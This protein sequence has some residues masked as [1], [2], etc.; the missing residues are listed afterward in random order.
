MAHEESRACEQGSWFVVLWSLATVARLLVV[1]P[2]RRP[3]LPAGL[4][5]E[6][7]SLPSCG[8]APATQRHACWSEVAACRPHLLHH[9]RRLG[10]PR[11]PAPT[12]KHSRCR[13]QSACEGADHHCIHS[14]AGAQALDVPVQRQGLQGRDR[15]WMGEG[16]GQE[17]R[18]AAVAAR[19]SD[20]APR[21]ACRLRL[22][23]PAAS[24]RV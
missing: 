18:P 1:W 7:M 17:A 21:P 10:V 12:A 15:G 23:S 14:E 3:G 9:Q 4:V 19:Q 8:P 11:L 22:A 5:S 24:Q 2:A 16:G 6:A 20:L 13:L